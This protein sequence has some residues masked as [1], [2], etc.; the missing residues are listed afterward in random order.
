MYIVSISWK[1][2]KVPSSNTSIPGFSYD[3]QYY[4]ILME[5]VCI[6]KAYPENREF[7][8]LNMRIKCIHKILTLYIVDRVSWNHSFSLRRRKVRI[9][10]IQTMSSKLN[11]LVSRVSDLFRPIGV[12]IAPGVQV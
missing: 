5:S 8:K 3:N 12:S 6:E 11:D 4:T 7:P 10:V 2:G 1:L 9:S